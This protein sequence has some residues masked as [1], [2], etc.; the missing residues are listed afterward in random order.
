MA[1][2]WI[3]SSELDL[4]TLLFDSPG[5][6]QEMC[7]AIHWLRLGKHPRLHWPALPAFAKDKLAYS[8]NCKIMSE[9]FRFS[10]SSDLRKYLPE[11]ACEVRPSS[12]HG[13]GVFA[14]RDVEPLRYLTVYPCDGVSWHP[15]IG[16]FQMG[17]DGMCFG[18]PEK[19]SFLER[20]TYQQEVE[21]PPGARA[22]AIYGNPLLHDDPHFV[23][24]M[25]N[26]GA[27]CK[28][29]ERVEIYEE[30]SSAKANCSFI[31][32]WGVMISLKPIKAGEELLTTYGSKYWLTLYNG[33]VAQAA[34]AATVCLS[35][36]DVQEELEKLEGAA[37]HS[38]GV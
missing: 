3:D 2:S 6:Q 30:I 11:P 7:Q 19:V 17:N 24:H 29:P 36:V 25:I 18:W 4:L 37:C 38:D 28:S 12:I 13:L 14:T 15:K 22:M 32:I 31:S 23:G 10:R 26:D 21:P 1:Y 33:Q 16:R 34:K 8:L 5:L 9:A 20:H 35:N 27:T